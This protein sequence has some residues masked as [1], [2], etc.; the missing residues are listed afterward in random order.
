MNRI[1]SYDVA[2]PVSEVKWAVT[3][4]SDGGRNKVKADGMISAPLVA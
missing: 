2:T 1:N 4:A 3:A